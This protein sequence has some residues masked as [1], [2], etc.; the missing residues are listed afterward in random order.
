MS[1]GKFELTHEYLKGLRLSIRDGED[2]QIL[3]SL[4]GVMAADVGAVMEELNTLEC[5]YVLRLLDV[6]LGAQVI[7][8]VDEDERAGFL[9]H[10]SAEELAPF[11]NEMDSDDAVD[12]LNQLSV[13]KRETVIANLKDEE[14]ANYIL[15]LLRYEEDCAGGL[16]AKE[17]I[18]VNLNWRVKQG[19][20]EIRRQAENVSKLYT[21]YVVDDYDKLLGRVS[22][23]KMILSHD[24]TR[25]SDIYESDIISVETFL[26]EEEVVNL[27]RKYDLEVVPVVNIR[28]ILVGRITIDDV[29]DVMTEQVEEE[30]QIMAGIS[31]DVEED[32]GVWILSR[33]RL[34]WLMIG[35]GG[36]LLAARFIGLFNEVAMLAP[37]IPLITATGG[38][39]GLQSSSLVLQSMANPSA[40]EDSFFQRIWKVMLVGLVNG[41][42]LAS[43]VLLIN[44]VI[45]Y[46]Q[47]GLALNYKLS[48]V[49]SLALFSVVMLASIMGTALPIMMEK[50][51][52]NP[53]LA[54]GPFITIANDLLGLAIYFS[55]AHMLLS[56]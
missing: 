15:D 3:K 43:L 9:E 41:L 7:T 42:A 27:M 56:I 19:I 54:S 38:N 26:E 22:L 33:A 44:L 24:S 8:G 51:G 32:D 10:F 21:L 25:I 2:R 35:M 20:E 34:P 5:I 52:I 17:L 12:L 11:V 46:S 14:S 1:L 49:V 39:V 31:E 4:E 18:K 50:L 53:A 6:E 36:G 55:V 29:I 45:G 28:G 23:K 30:R 40:F 48:V 37:F 16:M 13:K 47:D